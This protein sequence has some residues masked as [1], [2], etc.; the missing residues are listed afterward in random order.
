MLALHLIC[1][2]ARHVHTMGG[3]LFE[4]GFWDIP[5]AKGQRLVGGMLYL[6]ETKGAR[7]YFGGTVEAV[8][9]AEALSL[10]HISEPTRPY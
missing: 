4:S 6:H 10:I 2:S 9:I 3:G 1:R 8:R 7:S 5:V